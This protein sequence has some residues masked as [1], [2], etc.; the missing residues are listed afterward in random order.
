MGKSI[1]LLIAVIIVAGVSL[2]LLYLYLNKGTLFRR[3]EEVVPTPA[4][5]FPTNPQKGQFGYEEPQTKVM[6]GSQGV[7]KG[8]FEKVEGGN[9][10]LREGNTLTSLP[11]TLEEVVLSCTKQDLAVA[12]ELD[13]DQVTKVEIST[14]TEIGSL[15]PANEPVVTFAQD[16]AGTLRV[17]TVAM[18]SSKCR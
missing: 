1:K 4:V 16:V 8:T 6:I 5:A 15:I 2:S 14:P 12:L 18:D 10:F 9:I 7:T 13:F 17:H 11:L 3:G